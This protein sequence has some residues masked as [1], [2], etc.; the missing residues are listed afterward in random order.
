MW[1]V[2]Q[3]F[4]PSIIPGR[5]WWAWTACAAPGP[6]VT[7]RRAAPA[8]AAAD[9]AFV[10]PA[11]C[12]VA[13]A[14]SPAMA[15]ATPRRATPPLELAASWTLVRARCGFQPPSPPRRAACAAPTLTAPCALMTCV[16][17]HGA[18]VE[19]AR[20][21]VAAGARR[22]SAPAT[23]PPPRPVSTRV[24]P[25]FLAVCAL[26]AAAAAAGASVA[27]HRHTATT[28][29]RWGTVRVP[30]CRRPPPRAPRPPLPR[31]PSPRHHHQRLVGVVAAAAPWT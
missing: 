12:I 30:R 7:A 31:P 21:T 16:A 14:A 8:C 2:R 20:S 29:V 17:A 4:R 13:R 15:P 26:G 25:T 5:L 27:S 22:R 18:S 1:Q 3:A 10:V 9:G 28:G 23:L 6:E 11:S 24:G 19:G